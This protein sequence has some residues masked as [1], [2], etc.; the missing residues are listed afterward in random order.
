MESSVLFSF[1][2]H[3]PSIR[4][5]LSNENNME[6]GGKKKKKKDDTRKFETGTLYSPYL[7]L[8]CV[9]MSGVGTF[10]T[11]T[12]LLQNYTWFAHNIQILFLYIIPTHF[13]FWIKLFKYAITRFLWI[14]WTYSRTGPEAVHG[15]GVSCV[16]VFEYYLT[17][18][19]GIIYGKAHTYKGRSLGSFWFIMIANHCKDNVV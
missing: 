5:H 19:L 7:Y 14:M 15:K 12:D 2:I 8:L 6:N 17:L 16:V 18:L 1:Y 9:K 10:H 13:V 4:W 11:E 3:T